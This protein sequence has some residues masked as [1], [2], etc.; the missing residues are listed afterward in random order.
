M[1]RIFDIEDCGKWDAI[2]QSF[3]Q[4]DVYYLSG[5]L[6]A[7]Q[8]NGDGTPVLI[9]VELSQI[10][11]MVV[12]MKRDVADEKKL[13]DLS[14][15]QY[16]DLITPYGYGGLLFEGEV[17]KENILAVCNE[18]INYY[19]SQN[20]I[21]EFV[22]WHPLIQNVEDVRGVLD[23]IDLGHTIHM[24]LKSK[25]IIWNNITSKNRNVIR[26]AIKKGIKIEHSSDP[27]LFEIFRYLYNQTMTKDNAE[28]YYF[29][30][31]EFYESIA[32]DL[33]GNYQLF[34][35]LLDNKIIAMSIIIFANGKMHYHLSGSLTEYR[36]Y[37]PS[38]L[39]LYEAACWGVEQGFK[40][41]H[42]GGGVGS[43]EDNLF[44]FKQAFNRY[45]RNQFSIS[46][47]VYEQDIYN[48]LVAYRSSIDC[49]FNP[50]SKFFPLYRS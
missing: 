10:R 18:L 22:R 37:N 6:K 32:K 9:Y 41:F 28:D 17:K 50:E 36:T 47:I 49:G 8:L 31:S 29:F 24:D 48:E 23:V 35:A 15:G 43:G 42:M 3:Q 44:K 27:A 30:P 38:N 5:Y 16:F 2:V 45:S 20:I 46:K 11:A 26:S 1:I 7:F 34:Y 13:P 40:T 39:L 4:Y 14:H 33:V 21:C 25:E 12:Y 19:R